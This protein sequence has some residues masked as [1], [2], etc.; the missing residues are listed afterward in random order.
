M[1]DKMQFIVRL[2]QKVGPSNNTNS[3]VGQLQCD[4]DKHILTYAIA[5]ECQM[6]YITKCGR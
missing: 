6:D 4:F 5:G 1:P 2:P 3:F